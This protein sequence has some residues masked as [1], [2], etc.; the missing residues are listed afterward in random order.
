[1]LNFV[2]DPDLNG[3]NSNKMCWWN[4]PMK[5]IFLNLLW[6]YTVTAFPGSSAGKES[7]CNAGDPGLITG[8]GRSTGEGIG[9]PLQC[10][11]ASLVA[12]MIKYLSVMQETWVQPL[13]W[14]DDMEKGTATCSH[15]LPWRIPGTGAPGRLQC[16]GS[17]RVGHDWETFK[18]SCSYSLSVNFIF[19]SYSHCCCCC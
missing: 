14:E 4:G 6:S 8:L 12:Q 17:Q 3:S 10:S 5:N 15:I 19:S 16:L 1:M 2:H 11:W 7:T 13:S 18:L 9:Y